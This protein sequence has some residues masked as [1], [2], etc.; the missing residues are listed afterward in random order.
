MA[1]RRGGAAGDRR[2]SGTLIEHESHV[3]LPEVIEVSLAIM[4]V[5]VLALLTIENLLIARASRRRKASAR[6]FVPTT[7]RAAPAVHDEPGGL[8]Y[9]DAERAMTARLLAGQLDPANYRDAMAALAATEQ[10][11][12]G[13]DLVRL[14]AHGRG[15]SGQV[16]QLRVAMPALPPATIVAA[17]ALAHNGATVANLMR[18]LRLTNAQALRIIITTATNGDRRS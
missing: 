12:T 7:T 16:A 14:V 10:R 18:Q 15:S 2:R 11:T 17:V 5:G 4:V 3:R 9:D 8:A 6:A 13:V 1:N